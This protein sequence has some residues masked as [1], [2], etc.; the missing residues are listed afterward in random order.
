MKRVRPTPIAVIFFGL[1]N[2]ICIGMVIKLIT[3]QGSDF[4]AVVFPV[5]LLVGIFVFYLFKYLGQSKIEFDESSFIVDGETYNYN[6]ITNAVVD[7]KQ[8]LRGIPTLKIT[9]CKHGEEI[10]DF[11]KNDSGAK[12]FIYIIKKH[13]VS[14]NIDI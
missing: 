2:V 12:E 11:T 10:C 5:L 6:E 3:E 4:G 9:L 14:I 8:I 7:S 1:I 13:G